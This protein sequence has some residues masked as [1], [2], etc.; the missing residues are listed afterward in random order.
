[1]AVKVVKLGIKRPVT[2][3]LP[4]DP[5]P[6]EVKATLV[7][8]D[9]HVLEPPHTFEGRLPSRLQE[10][11]PRVVETEEGHQVWVFEDQP[12]FQ[13]GFMCVAGRR[14][15]DY[16]MEPSR[17]DEVR[18]GCY[19]IDDRIKDMDLGGIWASMN[20][21]SGVTGFAGTLFSDAKDKELGLACMRA[22]NDWIFE[23]WHSAYPERIIPLGVTFLADPEKGAEEIRRNAARGFHS[24]T[25]PEQPHRLGYP[26][27]FDPHWDPIIEACV[28]T[29]TVISLHVASSGF[30]SMPPG[31]PGL[32]LGAT[33]FTQLS[34]GT[35][36]EWLW[37]GYPARYPDL[38]IV[39]SEG[40]IGWVAYL[41]DRLDAIMAR[42]GYGQGW[43]DPKISPSD[44]LRRNFWFTI[45]DD[46]STICTRDTIGV[47]NIVFESD[48]PH[49][50]GSWPD[51][52][53]VMEKV[54]AGLPAED[55][56]KISH[57]NAAKLYHHP[58]PENCVP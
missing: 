7:S 13:V 4:P 58:L 14:K 28:D 54:F 41:I 48:Y 15:E 31:A 37:S 26:A 21:P 30:P 1:M 19:L 45:I 18:P 57:E 42:S 10:A 5:E 23:E 6:R 44:A 17:Y 11:A 32:E 3:G 46:P 53:L 51:T 12:Y 52:Q 40:G 55:I 25:L 29:D 16:R 9:D 38:K 24:V 43:P 39:L 8:V 56:R 33:L 2:Q 20:F 35:A 50:D 34:I 49:G 22:W 27:I 36:S 47:E